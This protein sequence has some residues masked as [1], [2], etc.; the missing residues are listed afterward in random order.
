MLLG[1]PNYIGLLFV[2]MT[3]SKE[4]KTKF[5]SEKRIAAG[6]NTHE[7]QELNKLADPSQLN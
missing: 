3:Y 5:E 1:Y 6:L 4:L 7:F 2:G